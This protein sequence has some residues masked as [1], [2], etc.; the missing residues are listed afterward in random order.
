[1]VSARIGASNAD[2]IEVDFL[3]DTGTFYSFISPALCEQIGI[4]LVVRRQAVAA[5]N[6]RLDVR[7]GIA[8]IEID[9]R[10]AAIIVGGLDVPVPL[11]GVEALEALGFKVNPVDQTLEQ[12]RPFPETPILTVLPDNDP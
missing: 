11:L 3:V 2:V 9:G 8:Y 10:D 6:R 7:M 4:E 12:T 1:M 5:D